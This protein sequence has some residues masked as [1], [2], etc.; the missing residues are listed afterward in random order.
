MTD[1][2]EDRLIDT[3]LVP[4]LR[5]LYEDPVF[6]VEQEVYV[7]DPDGFIDV[8]LTLPTHRLTIE[9]TNDPTTSKE[10]AQAVEYA[11]HYDDAVPVIAAPIDHL[12][13]D[14]VEIWTSY[15]VLVW[16]IDPENG[17]IT[18]LGAEKERRAKAG[19]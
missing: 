3:V 9:V 4:S 2:G 11:S 1:I 5:A 16:G 15:G 19:D 17:D 7:R 10:A 12:D 13:P 6:D 18:P 14:V 8:V